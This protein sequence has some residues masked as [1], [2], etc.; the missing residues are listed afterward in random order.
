MLQVNSNKKYWKLFTLI[1]AVALF[2]LINFDDFLWKMEDDRTE[3]NQIGFELIK[4][5][6]LGFL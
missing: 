4:L 5:V 1:L 6:K 2:M 3:F